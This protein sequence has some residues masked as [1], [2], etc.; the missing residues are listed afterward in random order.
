METLCFE[1]TIADFDLELLPIDAALLRAEPEIL[2]KA[3]VDYL[4]VRFKPLGGKSNIAVKD[5]HVA[6]TW[7]PSSLADHEKLFEH[8]ISLLHQGAYKQA[9]PILRAL[10]RHSKD[11]GQIALNLGMM[12]SDQQRLDEAIELLR[13]A[14][15]KL[16]DSADAWN[17]LGVAYQRNRKP[18][19]ATVALQRSHDLSPDNPYTL[20]NLGA[21]LTESA[22]DLAL[23]YLRRAAEL[24]P[25][26]QAS[27][28]G[29]ALA[30]LGAGDTETADETFK[31]AIDIAP[32]NDLAERCR[33]ERTKIAH[34]GMR[35]R[36]GELRMDV[37]MY[38]LSALDLFEKGGKQKMGMITM[39]VAMLG[40]SGLDIN[41]SAQK[42]SLKSLSGK[43][44]GLH[45]LAL[46][47]T[48]LKQLAPEQ[49]AGVDFSR[50]YA[51]A[52]N[53]RGKAK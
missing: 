40:R 15:E 5:D 43:F 16:P 20:R 24:L 37:V 27:M 53:M 18:D 49:D 33:K 30:L 4:T 44:S 6:V 50:E 3:V 36:G 47:Y 14:T 21:L 22:P 52:L 34:V 29:Y 19:L 9:E 45:L 38:I 39:E 31:K 32:F 23:V 1:F 48:G 25:N 26:D 17:A 41:D 35:E 8:A 51:Q 12:L 7:L 13:N 46:M 42:Y 2:Q 10:L 28:Y 11:N